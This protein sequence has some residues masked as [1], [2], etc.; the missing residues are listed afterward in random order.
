[1][2]LSLKKSSN[3]LI[4]TCVTAVIAAV[5]SSLCCIAALI[6]LLFGVSSSWLIKLNQ[7]DFL[8][9]P[10]LVISLIAFSYGFWLL[11]FSRKIVCTRYLSRRTLLILYFVV[12]GVILFFL[13]YPYLLPWILEQVE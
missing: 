4:A 1:M 5:T 12:F 8:R 11:V 3:R 2:N 7:F 10:M 6:Y 9:M 13:F